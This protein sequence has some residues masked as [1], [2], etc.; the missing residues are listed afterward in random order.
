[1]LA[2]LQLRPM[3]ND[4]NASMRSLLAIMRG[5]HFAHEQY[6]TR[7]KYIIQKYL[8]NLLIYKRVIIDIFVNHIR[9]S[10]TYSYQLSQNL[11]QSVYTLR[12]VKNNYI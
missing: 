8:N 12:K 6:I 10:I 11:F 1:M 9:F 4:F 2:I 7:N 5:R 3:P